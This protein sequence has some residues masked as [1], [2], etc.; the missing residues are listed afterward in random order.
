[1]TFCNN[2]A[3]NITP[4]GST[5]TITGVIFVG[6]AV[7]GPYIDDDAAKAA[8]MVSGQYYY[9]AFPNSYDMPGGLTKRIA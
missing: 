6:M 9:L 4:S 7:Q 3:I 8:G 5:V 2:I 1:M